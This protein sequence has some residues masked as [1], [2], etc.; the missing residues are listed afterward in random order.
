MPAEVKGDTPPPLKSLR[1]LFWEV[2]NAKPKPSLVEKQP[3][4][5]IGAGL[6]R[7][8]TASFVAALE[9]VGL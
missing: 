5:V 3:I 1:M 8:G 9:Q 4:M 2:L 7:T 6:P